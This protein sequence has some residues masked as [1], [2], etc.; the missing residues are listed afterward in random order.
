MFYSY[1]IR[2]TRNLPL[3]IASKNMQGLPAIE[4]KS[5]GQYIIVTPSLSKDNS[6]KHQI[7]GNPD[8]ELEFQVFDKFDRHIDTILKEFNISYLDN[9]INNNG[10]IP[11][12]DLFKEDTIIY[13]G[14]NRHEAQL[15]VN[16]SL[17]KRNYGILS[18][19][20]I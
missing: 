15:R 7:I 8:Q 17:L 18:L 12:G 1:R 19:D 9:N 4:V 2:S 10:K 5:A 13:E 11:I 3:Q 16:D 6:N 20:Q 14:H